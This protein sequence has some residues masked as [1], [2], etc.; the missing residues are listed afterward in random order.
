MVGEGLCDGHERLPV[1]LLLVYGAQLIEQRLEARQQIADADLLARP[2][3]KLLLKLELLEPTILHLFGRLGFF[4][5]LLVHL[6][7][8]HL[9]GCGCGCA[10]PTARSHVAW[11][12]VRIGGVG[13]SCVHV[14]SSSKRLR[15]WKGNRKRTR[16]VDSIGG[17]VMGM[18]P[19]HVDGELASTF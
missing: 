19:D 9:S 18:E 1:R 14:I 5:H 10:A 13:S 17:V 7:V 2:A 16:L 3:N 8:G 12:R 11:L 15:A 6:V 4:L